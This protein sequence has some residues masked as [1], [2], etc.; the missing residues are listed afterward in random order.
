MFN[1]DNHEKYILAVGYENK[2]IQTQDKWNQLNLMEI[3]SMLGT[4]HRLPLSNT[5]KI[6]IWLE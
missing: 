5:A 3:Q 6:Y 1:I 2:I 4:N